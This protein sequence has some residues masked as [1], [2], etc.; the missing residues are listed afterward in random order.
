M[1]F[2]FMESLLFNSSEIFKR[3]NLRSENHSVETD[4]SC[5]CVYSAAP[6]S[7]SSLSA[8]HQRAMILQ[9]QCQEYLKKAEYALQSVSHDTFCHA[10]YCLSSSSRTSKSLPHS[11][12]F[13]L[14]EK[15]R[16]LGSCCSFSCASGKNDRNVVNRCIG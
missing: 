14:H 3:D 16:G 5:F 11:G 15:D 8:I 7:G 13:L 9:G 2:D 6:C 10:I 12:G 1:F 4:G